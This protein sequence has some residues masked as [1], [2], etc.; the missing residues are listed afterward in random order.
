MLHVPPLPGSPQAKDSF[1]TVLDYVLRDAAALV[2]GGMTNLMIENFGDTPFF[3]GTVPAH[4]VAQ[5]T[6][7]AREVSSRFP[8]AELGLNVLRN[9]GC[10]A[11]AI[12]AATGASFIR[13]NILCGARLTDQGII[14]GIAHD[15]LRLRKQLAAEDVAILADVDV[16]HSAS[17]AERPLADEIEDAIKR[18]HADAIIVSGNATGAAVDA[19][20][21]AK[22]VAAAGSTPVL[23]GSGATAES[24]REFRSQAAGFIVGTSVKRD[25]HVH[26]PVDP[27][28]VREIVAR[29][30]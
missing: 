16:K 2:E 24:I 27:S 1:A 22:A 26:N 21:L 12:A 28:R 15:L 23:I 8:D 3:P 30:G 9:D 20:Q 7:I 4:T 6:A 11:L 10:S 29:I 18:G 13:V 5:L 19:G 17:L 14:Q 25:G